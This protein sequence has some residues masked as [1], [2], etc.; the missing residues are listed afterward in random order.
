MCVLRVYGT[1]LD[2]DALVETSTLSPC[3]T[4]RR[5][6]PRLSTKPEGPRSATSGVNISVS[7]A[8]W[9]DL[10]GQVADAERFLRDHR[11][12]ISKLRVFPGVEGLT[13]D[14]PVELRIGKN[15][16]AQCDRFPASLVAIAGELG[17]SLELSIYP[18][19]RE[20]DEQTV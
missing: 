17:L 5:G 16:W 2:V 18:P 9:R 11:E 15:V 13:L 20:E 7:D 10:R 4:Y 3:R 6:E 8:S 19:A 1:Q 14:F 12:E